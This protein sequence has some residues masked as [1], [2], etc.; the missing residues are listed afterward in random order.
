MRDGLSK[1]W[2]FSAHKK[3]FLFGSGC[4]W[5]WNFFVKVII[6]LAT[7]AAFEYCRGKIFT[8]FYVPH[9][10]TH[11][12]SSCLREDSRRE[13]AS[14]SAQKPSPK[15]F[16]LPFCTPKLCVTIFHKTE[17][18][19]GSPLSAL[20]ASFSLSLSLSN[21]IVVVLYFPRAG[22]VWILICVINSDFC[23]YLLP[24]S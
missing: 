20:I 16:P 13:M 15:K 6:L 24:M 5:K 11:I 8:L 23:L 7:L 22:A 9:R 12:S 1:L 3:L 21:D 17:L 2:Q 4:V 18:Y 14:F 19:T 10:H